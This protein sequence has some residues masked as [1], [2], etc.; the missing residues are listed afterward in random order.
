MKN[1]Y[2]G[3]I[4]DFGK[5]SLLR[6]FSDR[7]IRVGVNWYLTEDDGSNDGKFTG[8]LE[9]GDLRKYSPKVFDALKKVVAK[10]D[11]SVEDIEKSGILSDAIFF[12]ELLKPVGTPGDREQERMS[13]FRESVYELE[14]AELIFLDPDNGLFRND[15]ASAR[16]VEKYVLPE[17]VESYFLSGKNVV[18]YCHK[19][20]R[21]ENQWN[22]HKRGMFDRIKD[23]KPL[24]I[25][26]HKGSQRS[27]IFLVHDKDYENYRRILNDFV[28]GWDEMFTHEVIYSFGNKRKAYD[29]SGSL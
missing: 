12:N 15:D 16:G 14:R 7:G 24:A 1:Q 13:W 8:Y 23:A 17:E 22:E 5:Y 20:R 26:Y 6:A 21:P 19:G 25:T 9:K 29:I 2:V 27:Y 11:K 18:Y 10:P 28:N 3:D 4:G